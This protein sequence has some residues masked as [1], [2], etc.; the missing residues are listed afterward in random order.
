MNWRTGSRIPRYGFEREYAVRVLG[1]LDADSRQKLLEGVNLA[2]GP[3]R[4]ATVDFA[5]GDGSNRW[6]RVVIGEGRN[7]EVRRMFEAV[8]LTVS[9][10]IR[11]RYGGVPSAAGIEP[12]AAGKNSTRRLV[13]RWCTE[14]GVSIQGRR[15]DGVRI[16]PRSAARKRR[17][18]SIR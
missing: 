1:E 3:A 13:K 6:Y 16:R 17:G 14:L 10:L 2:D 11:I 9:R 4:F 18:R 5:G 8:G 12:R 15:Q 7:R